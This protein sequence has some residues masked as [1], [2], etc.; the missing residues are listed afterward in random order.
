MRFGFLNNFATQIATPVA[1]TDT[2]IELAAG[3]ADIA[4]ALQNA[5]AV[6]LTL[7]ATDAQGNETKREVVYAT[8]ATPPMVTVT[9]AQEDTTALAFDPGDGAEGRLT[10]QPLNDME[11]ATGDA[12]TT[13]KG[14][15][16]YATETETADAL[17]TDKTITPSGLHAYL[18]TAATADASAFAAATHLHLATEV[19]YD[20]TTSGATPVQ[21][22]AALDDIYAQ[23]ADVKGSTALLT[24]ALDL[25][26]AGA[27]VTLSLP[28]N[29][30]TLPD[31]FDVVIVESDTPGG[32]PEIQIGP[33]DVTPA[34]YLAAT[35][36]TK[37]AVGGRE[38]HTPLVTDG[39]TA[40]RVSV[41]T[42]GTGTAYKVKVVARGYVM[43][44]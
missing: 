3:A 28:A 15:T 42:A 22:Q 43:E 25:T 24:A 37:T 34:A 10:A 5:D 1:D 26:V 7:F 16:Q 33:D 30:V 31:A 41:V 36:V 40:L 20:N 27:A 38:T 12:S 21:A 18:G 35:P 14:I 29:V 4:T 13:A 19:E 44:I 8:A 39:I 32:T 6:A 11:L 2:S 9:R 23:L 17:V